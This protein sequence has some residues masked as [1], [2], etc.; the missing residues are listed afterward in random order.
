MFSAPECLP[1]FGGALAFLTQIPKIHGSRFLNI[2]FLALII[3]F[4]ECIVAE[5]CFFTRKMEINII[6]I[7]CREHENF[8]LYKCPLV[9]MPL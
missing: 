1:A 2:K 6:L 7:V 9:T 8:H 5:P 3:H 4:V